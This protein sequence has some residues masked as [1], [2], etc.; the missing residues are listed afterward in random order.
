MQID[1]IKRIAEKI[2][3]PRRPGAFWSELTLRLGHLATSGDSERAVDTGAGRAH[4]LLDPR[5][6]APAPGVGWLRRTAP[7]RPAGGTHGESP[8]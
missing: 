1:E 4:H 3:H 7:R 6:G 8:P 5:T 2:Y